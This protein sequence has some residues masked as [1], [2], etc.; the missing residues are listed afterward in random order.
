MD[1]HQQDVPGY[2]RMRPADSASGARVDADAVARKKADDD[3]R[4]KAGAERQRLAMLQK[5][6]ERRRSERLAGE[7][8][9]GRSWGA[10]P[11]RRVCDPCRHRR[12]RRPDGPLHP[13]RG[14]QEQPDEAADDHRQQGRRRGCGRLPGGQEV[15]RRPAQHHHHPVQPVHHA[16]RHRRA[17]QLEGHDP[18]RHAGARP[19]RAV[20]ASRHPLQD[21]QGVHR[22]RSRPATTSPSRWAAPAPSRK[23]RSSPWRWRS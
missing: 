5:E 16:L 2:C 1:R 15:R 11:A 3:A 18:G 10:E 13:G 14:G 23:T 19:V 12:R 21:R 22:A 17:L 7:A 9:R 8:A 6:E 20:G 4:T